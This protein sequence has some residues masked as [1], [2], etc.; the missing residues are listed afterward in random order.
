MP[1]NNS[2]KESLYKHFVKFLLKEGAVSKESS[3]L[4]DKIT[5]QVRDP[6]VDGVQSFLEDVMG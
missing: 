2:N 1:K 4:K 6:F 3:L 5:L